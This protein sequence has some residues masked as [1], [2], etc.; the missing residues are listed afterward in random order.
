MMNLIS[1]YGT[2][3][4]TVSNILSFY[5]NSFI[6]LIESRVDTIYLALFTRRDQH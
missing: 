4:Q 5:M 2:P 1:R 3:L 6:L